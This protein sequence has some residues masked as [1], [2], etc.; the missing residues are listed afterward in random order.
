MEVADARLRPPEVA[1]HLLARRRVGAGSVAERPREPVLGHRVGRH[2]VGPALVGELQRVLDPTERPVGPTELRRV[3][4][5]D[6]P[7][8]RERGQRGHRPLLAQRPVGT[9]VDE[10]EELDGELDVADPPGP[11]LELTRTLP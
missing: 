8:R 6:V 9:P 7:V 10:L 1:H 5:V 2:R 4:L 3:L 11:E